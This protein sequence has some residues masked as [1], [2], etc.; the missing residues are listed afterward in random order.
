M[1]VLSPPFGSERHRDISHTPRHLDAES[2]PG[3]RATGLTAEKV[4]E[5]LRAHAVQSR[6]PSDVL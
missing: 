4:V 1:S 2:R 6:D 5:A 3:H